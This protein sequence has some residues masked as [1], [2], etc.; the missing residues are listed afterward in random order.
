[1][2][3]RRPGELPRAAVVGAGRMGHGIALE[4]ARGGYLVSIYDV[5]R[6]RARQAITEAEQDATDL[7]AAGVIEYSTRFPVKILSINPSACM[8]PSTPLRMWGMTDSLQFA[9]VPG[10]YRRIILESRDV[11]VFEPT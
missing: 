2:T 6:G 10:P 8:R 9:L 3:K 5:Q 1:M 4:L 11:G 7:I